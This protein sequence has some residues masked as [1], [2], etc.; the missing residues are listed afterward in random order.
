MRALHAAALAFFSAVSVA[1][2]AADPLGLSDAIERIRPSV[3]QVAAQ[4]RD[5]DDRIIGEP[6]N[7]LGTGFLVHESGV[8]ATAEHV[9]A[10]AYNGAPKEA[11]RT[12]ILVAFAIPNFERRGISMTQSFAF[13]E[14]AAIA[15]DATADVALLRTTKPFS[16]SAGILASSNP[17][18]N[19][20]MRHRVAVLSSGPLRDGERVA[21]SGYPLEEPVL[22]T[23]SGYIAGSPIEQLRVP[24]GHP[25]WPFLSKRVV[26]ADMQVNFGNSGGPVYRVPDGAVVGLTSQYKNTWLVSQDLEVLKAG[27]KPIPLNSGLSVIAPTDHILVVAA[28]HGID[29]V[30]SQSARE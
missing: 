14:V 22:I 2:N 13:V 28:E 8:F 12:R 29:L 9:V 15:R 26:L 30:P 27:D 25:A 19:V 17:S 18:E 16:M 4:W 11:R 7:T 21:T 1:A 3:V 5:A 20:T 23:T 6:M 10:A 24:G